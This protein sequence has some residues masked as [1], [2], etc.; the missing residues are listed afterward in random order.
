MD[1]SINEARTLAIQSLLPN[2]SAGNQAYTQVKFSGR[3]FQNNRLVQTTLLISAHVYS[4]F[5]GSIPIQITKGVIMADLTTVG[6]L[7][8]PPCPGD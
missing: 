1:Q 6:W 3:H 7:K 4:I 5:I 8:L 2:P